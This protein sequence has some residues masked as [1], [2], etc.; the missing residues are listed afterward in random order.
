MF[1]QQ[2]SSHQTRL[3]TNHLMQIKIVV[4]NN[5][6]LPGLANEPLIVEDWY[7]DDE[8]DED[9]LDGNLH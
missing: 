8:V 1:Q 9:V 2:E 7:G 3:Q 4:T 5:N 6:V